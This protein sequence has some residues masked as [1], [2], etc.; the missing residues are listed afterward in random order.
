MV[1][2]Y[3]VVQ[4][5]VLPT[6]A[7]YKAVFHICEH[8]LY[9]SPGEI[10]GP[11]GGEPDEELNIQNILDLPLLSINSLRKQSPLVSTG[12]IYQFVSKMTQ[13]LT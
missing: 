7:K 9:C 13:C 4:L 11:S 5:T 10:I 8:S 6:Q 12:C 3:R 1:S 2:E